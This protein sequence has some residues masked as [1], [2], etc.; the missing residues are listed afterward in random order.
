MLQP[1]TTP[2]RPAV[3]SRQPARDYFLSDMCVDIPS[4][5]TAVFKARVN[6]P[7]GAQVWAR[8]WLSNEVDGTLAEAASGPLK[9]GELVALTVTLQDRRTPEIACMRIES[10]PLATEQV[11]IIRLVQG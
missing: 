7:A 6:G 2:L 11:V 5:D 3:G 1:T 8:A 4:S 9:A 10:A